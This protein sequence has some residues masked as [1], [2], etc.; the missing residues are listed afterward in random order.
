L[1]LDGY[2]AFT[3]ELAAGLARDPRV[4]GLVA[5]GSMAERDYAPDEW[6]DHDF[7]LISDPGGQE[8]FRT[9][10]AWLP[11]AEEIVLSFRETAHGVKVV[12]ADGHL[13]EFAVFDLDELE[14]AGVNRYRVLVDRDGVLERRMAE[15]AA[16]PKRQESDEHLFGM[17]VTAALVAVGRTRRGEALSGS[18]FALS[19]RRH[20]CA[21]FARHLPSERRGVLDDLDPL[22]RFELAYPSLGAE[23]RDARPSRLLEIAERELRDRLPALP[24]AALQAVRLE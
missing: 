3:A 14:I 21:L 6:S 12:Y 2:R 11:R 16:R 15:L 18:F 5:V 24:W 19:C 20:L 10:L 23:L 7:F 4:V 8:S 1:R 22:R 17:A 9:D 13:L